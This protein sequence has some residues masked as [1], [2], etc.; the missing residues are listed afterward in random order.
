MNS[1]SD[2]VRH[3][4]DDGVE[5]E[6]LQKAAQP[7]MGLHAISM[8]GAAQASAAEDASSARYERLGQAIEIGRQK[9][10]TA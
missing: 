7:A 10:A 6:E 3:T 1:A 4:H 9:A 2:S 5:Q 8:A